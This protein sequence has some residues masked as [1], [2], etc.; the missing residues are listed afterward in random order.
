RFE[1]LDK[2]NRGETAKASF[3]YA[4]VTQIAPFI[5]PILED[6]DKDSILDKFD[7]KVNK[8]KDAL[9]DLIPE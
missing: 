9:R 7:R 3:L 1:L 6:I 2:F 4:P 8:A 5:L